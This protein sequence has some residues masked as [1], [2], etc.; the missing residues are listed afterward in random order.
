MKPY[1]YTLQD[2]FFLISI[3]SSISED[4]NTFATHSPSVPGCERP[5]ASFGNLFHW[6]KLRTMRYHHQIFSQCYAQHSVVDHFCIQEKG[7]G[8]YGAVRY[9]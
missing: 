8:P 6:Q 9:P 5:L 1:M 3:Q 4:G 2:F 7:L